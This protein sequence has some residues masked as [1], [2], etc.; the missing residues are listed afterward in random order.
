MR[1]CSKRY[2]SKLSGLYKI[3]VSNQMTLAQ[4]IE[5]KRRG[6]EIESGIRLTDRY[7]GEIAWQDFKLNDFYIT[8]PLLVGNK[9]ATGLLYI[10][11][12]LHSLETLQAKFGD[13]LGSGLVGFKRGGSISFNISSLAFSEPDRI[14][15]SD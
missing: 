13:C 7:D 1:K 9:Q 11:H 15:F 5:L 6:S 12:Y 4:L 14:F 10:C 2:K 3:A 8:F